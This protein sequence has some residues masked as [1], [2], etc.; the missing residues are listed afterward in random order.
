MAFVLAENCTLCTDFDHIFEAYDIHGLLMRKAELV[1]LLNCEIRF[2]I[3]YF[4]FTIC[5]LSA[6]IKLFSTLN[7]VN[8]FLLGLISM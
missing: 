3:G 8:D 1:L 5:I 7:L 4:L 2:R 6:G